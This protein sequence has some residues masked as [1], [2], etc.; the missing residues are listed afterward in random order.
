MSATYGKALKFVAFDVKADGEW[1]DIKEAEHSCKTLG[2]EFV[3]YDIVSATVEALDAARLKPSTQAVRNGITEPKPTE[4]VVIRPLTEM[5][6]PDGTRVIAKHKNPEFS[7]RTSKRDT[8]LDPDKKLALEA[9]SAV[10]D[11]FVT[12]ERLRHVLAKLTATGGFTLDMQHTPDVIRAM[13][14]DV[15]VEGEGEFEDTKDVRKAIG[16]AAA[17]MYKAM[18]SKI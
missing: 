1:L 9:A 3:H 16:A 7:E 11:E 5:T 17:K 10:A 15:T 8:Q 12:E 4:G 13:V 6:R 14:E 18:V 2:I